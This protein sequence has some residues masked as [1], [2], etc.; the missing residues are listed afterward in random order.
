M[1]FYF[2]ILLIVMKSVLAFLAIPFVLTGAYSIAGGL[3][4]MIICCVF[5]EE[6]MR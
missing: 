6:A 4:F 2:A 3:T 5:L 1:E